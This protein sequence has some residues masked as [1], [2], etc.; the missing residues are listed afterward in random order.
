LSDHVGVSTIAMTS[1]HQIVLWVQSRH[2]QESP[3]LL[4]PTGSGSLD[5]KDTVGKGNLEELLVSGMNREL[6]EESHRFGTKQINVKHIESKI[7]GFY[8]RLSRGGKPD[9]LGISRLP[10]CSSELAPNFT[11]V[12]D[13]SGNQVKHFWAV[14]DME[15]LEAMIDALLS[16][17]CISRLSVPLW[18]N[19]LALRDF[20]KAR[21]RAL[22]QFWSLQ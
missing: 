16:E 12:E 22:K 6:S 10:V 3:G 13:H 8:R 18:A 20:S 17:D 2:A 1:D 7:I 9:F 5:W 4:A 21:S 11:E 19:L 14:S 15:E